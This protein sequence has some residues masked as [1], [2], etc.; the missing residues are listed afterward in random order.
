M[1]EGYGLQNLVCTFVFLFSVIPFIAPIFLSYYWKESCLTFRL[2]SSR[3]RNTKLARPLIFLQWNKHDNYTKVGIF[4]VKKY[5]LLPFRLL[6]P[7]STL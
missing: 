6:F 1:R 2:L 5:H 4:L 7:L 3:K